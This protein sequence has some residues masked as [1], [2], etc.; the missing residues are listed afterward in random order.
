MIL[1]L[2]YSYRLLWLLLIKSFWSCSCKAFCWCFGGLTGFSSVKSKSSISHRE[3]K[4]SVWFCL[5]Q[6]M[7]VF[8][9]YWVI[10][11]LLC[12]FRFRLKGFFLS[13][14]DWNNTWL[15]CS[16]FVFTWSYGW[17]DFPDF[18]SSDFS[19]LLKKLDGMSKSNESFRY[20]KFCS[21]FW[22]GNLNC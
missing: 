9:F 21:S 11:W 17:L 14:A 13:A 20:T 18:G 16:C 22:I 8:L 2:F 12:K 10:F 5:L 6:M 19:L 15:I 3:S 1:N 4:F 7:M